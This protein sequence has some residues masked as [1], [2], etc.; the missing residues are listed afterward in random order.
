MQ[1]KNGSF[2]SHRALLSSL[3]VFR[4]LKTALSLFP[5]PY[6]IC[7]RANMVAR[8]VLRSKTA[9]SSDRVAY[10]VGFHV[11]LCDR[12]TEMVLKYKDQEIASLVDIQRLTAKD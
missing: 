6:W 5:T 9:D 8:L 10:V 1:V 3:D 11:L 12:S 7:N 2:R 4:S